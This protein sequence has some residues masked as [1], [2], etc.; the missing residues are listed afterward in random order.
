MAI[1]AGALV[2]LA[3]VLIP[4]APADTT[5]PY[6]A[7]TGTALAG[8]MLMRGLGT[9]LLVPVIEEL[10]F[11]D[12]LENRLHTWAGPMVAA[13]IT[14]GPSRCCTTARPSRRD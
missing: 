11:R 10:F 3:W 4:Y 9:V 14:P 5:P 12:Y 7:L 2:G 8:W 6:G 1:G 13:L